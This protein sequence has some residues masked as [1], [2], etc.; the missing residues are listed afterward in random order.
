MKAIRV[1]ETGGPEKL[2]LEDIP[3][4]QPQSGQVLVR[5]AAAGVNFIDIYQRT[6]LYPVP[7]PFTPGSP[8]CITL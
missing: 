7:P 6:G 4:P 5:V 1:N 3:V 2:V 8:R